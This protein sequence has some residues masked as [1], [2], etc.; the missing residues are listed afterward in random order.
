[1]R[2]EEEEKEIV[3]EEE[4][5]WPIEEK[6]SNISKVP[7]ELLGKHFI[8]L[9]KRQDKAFFTSGVPDNLAT[10]QSLDGWP[11]HCVFGLWKRTSPGG[12]NLTFVQWT[13]IGTPSP[14]LCSVHW[15]SECVG[16]PSPLVREAHGH[17]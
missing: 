4:E 16:H 14:S 10:A 9:L 2:R 11:E 8:H 5:N 15:A 17:Y 12:Y 13:Y 6:K 7:R 3:E 1:M